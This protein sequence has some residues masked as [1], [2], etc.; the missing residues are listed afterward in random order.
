MKERE[1]AVIA[2]IATG[3][4]SKEYTPELGTAFHLALENY[5]YDE[6]FVAVGILL[7][8]ADR[9]FAPNPGEIVG[10]I[11]ATK[12]TLNPARQYWTAKDNAPEENTMTPEQKAAQ[13]A[14]IRAK[15]PDL[16]KEVDR[17]SSLIKRQRGFDEGCSD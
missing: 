17:R 9:R 5:T 3:P 4:W 1:S 12:K 16:F 8:Q 13:V 2:K 11:Q 10:Q 15:F 14:E 6:A 7:K